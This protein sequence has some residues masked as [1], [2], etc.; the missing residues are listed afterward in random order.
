MRHLNFIKP[1]LFRISCLLFMLVQV[2]A[3]Q[4]QSPVSG[5]VLDDQ[6]TPLTGVT[7]KT[8]GG[9]QVV[10]TDEKGAFELSVEK[11]PVVL[12]LSYIGYETTSVSVSSNQPITVTMTSGGSKL[13]EVVVVA[14][15][16][17]KR[18][19]IVGSVAQ[20]GGE[21]LSKAPSM[22]ITNSLA[23][24]VPGLTTLQQSGRPGADD[25]TLR[26][27]G[28]STY[29]NA[30]PLIIIDGVERASFSYLDPTEIESL[31]FLKDAISTAPYGVRGSNGII[32]IT[33]K[34]GQQ[35]KPKFAYNA[36][37]NIGQNTRFPEFL[38]GPDYMEWYNKGV[39]VDN[40]YLIHTG[41][42]A[43]PILYDPALIEAV[44]NGTNTNP[45]FG[46]T[47][48]IGMLVG[49]NSV[50]QNHSLTMNGGTERLSYFG[51]VSHMHQDGVV[52]NTNFKRYNVRSNVEAKINEY[53]TAGINIGLRQ[54]LTNT[55]GIAPDNTAYMNPFYQAVRML[56]NM[57]MYAE[58]GLPVSYN[59][60][61]GW[62]NPIAAVQNSG[63]QKW[64][65]NILEGTANI[66]VKVPG[67]PGLEAR[68]ITSFDWTGRSTKGWLTPYE[69]MGRVREQVT[70][71]FTHLATLPG[72]TKNSVRQSYQNTQRKTFQPA[73][74]YNKVFGEDHAV[75]LLAV[76]DYSRLEGFIFSAGASNLPIDIIQDIDFGSAE[77][78]DRIAPTGGTNT[79][80]SKA[81]YVFRGT[82]GY[83][84]R[85]LLEVAS[86]WDA[87]VWFAP[88]NRWDIFPSVGLGW[89]ASDE[90]FFKDNV[91]FIDFLKIK[92]SYGKTGND[93][94]G[95]ARFAYL[96]T[97]SLNDRPVVVMDGQP[98]KALY[99]NAIANPD[100][101]WETT[102]TRSVGFESI[103]MNGKFGLDFE[104]YYKLTK[105]IL[106]QVG[107]LYPPSVGG[108]F[109]AIANIGEADNRGF[110]A[111]LRY[112]ER[113]GDFQLRL[114]GNI[115]WARNRYL[116]L[117]E[118]DNIPSWQ[119]LI[120]KPI[121][122]KIGFVVDGMVQSWEEAADTPSPS[123]G[124]VAPGF[125]KYRDLNGDGRITR[126]DDMTYIGRSNLPELMYGL[127]IDLAYKG[128]DF[129][130]LLQ[131]A[132]L[133]SVNLA[134]TYE[135]SSGTSGV[136]DNTPFTRTFYGY[137]NSPYF[138][139][140]NAWR[141]DNPDAEFPRLTA[142]KA[143]LSA[144]NAHKNSGWERKGDYL[145]LK[146]VQI[147]YTL[148]QRWIAGAKLQQVRFYATGSNL[149]T[150][151][152]LKYLDPE[153]PNVNN[154]FY[155]QQRIYA[156]GVNVTF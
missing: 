37:V 145:R 102:Y 112:N 119:S 7:V 103:F 79:P 66:N 121:G 98:V 83:K 120:G 136:D 65:R 97:L 106:G 61:A 23:G 18:R 135:G 109:P 155:P 88:H 11:Y 90:Q 94:V 52:E 14:Y 2:I 129:S 115:N 70:G 71:D 45:L 82:Y 29:G 118:G 154:G 42:S 111:Q 153:M 108:Y 80:E 12:E 146:S 38:N 91:S 20:I 122:T 8:R 30:A 36:G 100:V 34:K 113:F 81:G 87:S 93:Q 53:I 57:P 22:N 21:E 9:A 143:Q 144:H 132:G 64:T 138:L 69:T 4:G 17:Q 110:D 43:Q 35:G 131:G 51:A 54:E 123:G 140:E 126:N 28:V 128:F 86:R 68:V 101:R 31:S 16:T 150:F 47:D 77:D 25:A 137:G 95:N 55:P 60:N 49:R 156:F 75:G 148:P 105:D 92:G 130:A 151:D 99:T 10:S 139:V 84:D 33:T 89:I 59:S 56:P 15:G 124:I 50:S 19:N 107:N 32:M 74:Q 116:K 27:R 40:D 46:D 134:G 152:Y 78:D 96:A 85:Y 13:D 149:M 117:N 76:Y 125:F 48:W 24:R 141:P 127:N 26:I 3:V 6:K 133:S 114:T 104:W 63:Y 41:S 73:I 44:R 72:I 67:V 147:G 5:I 58:N 1:Y 62:V 142:Y 39:E